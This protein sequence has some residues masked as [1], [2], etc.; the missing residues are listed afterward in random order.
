MGADVTN[1]DG[2]TREGP[3]DRVQKAHFDDGV[4][5]PQSD[6]EWRVGCSMAAPVLHF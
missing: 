6:A 5:G 1:K 2:A 4:G 3:R